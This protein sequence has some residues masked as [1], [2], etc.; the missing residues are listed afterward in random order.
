VEVAAGQPRPEILRHGDQHR[1]L[2][3]LESQ[4][5]RL[6]SQVFDV[7]ITIPNPNQEL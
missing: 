3:R 2:R 5:F 1:P 4:V 7:E 6:E